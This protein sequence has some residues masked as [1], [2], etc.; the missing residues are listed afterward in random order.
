MAVARSVAPWSA[1]DLSSITLPDVI[2]RAIA[3]AK[4]ALMPTP[5]DRHRTTL[6]ADGDR[7]RVL[8]HIARLAQRADAAQD[9]LYGAMVLAHETGASFRDIAAAAGT[10]SS[11]TKRIV[12]N[13]R[14][15]L[16][17]ES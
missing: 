11:T 15:A 4:E 9:A 6:D 5:R 3:T 7:R 17:I 13:A 8:A 1:Y 14:T 12:D 16:A 2:G 10:S